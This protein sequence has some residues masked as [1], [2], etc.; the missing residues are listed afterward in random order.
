MHRAP[1]RSIALAAALIGLCAA[2]GGCGRK[3]PLYLPP[4]PAPPPAQTQTQSGTQSQTRPATAPAETQAQ[5][6][7]RP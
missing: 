7:D 4:E 1:C 5:A 3:G 2:A 6:P